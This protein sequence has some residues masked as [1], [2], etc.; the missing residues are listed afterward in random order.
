M[1]CLTRVLAVRLRYCPATVEA[2]YDT[3][4]F[5]LWTTSTYRQVSSDLSDPSHP[6]RYPWYLTKSCSASW[7]NCR[8]YCRVAQAAFVTTVL[9]VL[10][11]SLHL[12]LHASRGLRNF[13]RES[14]KISVYSVD[15]SLFK[16]SVPPYQDTDSTAYCNDALSPVLAFFPED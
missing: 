12:M 16:W 1:V 5:S 13:G 14:C 2:L 9:A 3:I 10:V 6:S 15:E 4:L 8:S 7:D 11:F